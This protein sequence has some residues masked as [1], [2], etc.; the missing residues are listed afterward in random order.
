MNNQNENQNVVVETTVETETTNALPSGMLL[1]CGAKKKTRSEVANILPVNGALGARHNPI[2][3]IET[4][5][6]ITEYLIH[7]GLKIVDEGFGVTPDGNR[8]FGLMK[9]E[10]EYSEYAPTIGIARSYNQTL[11]A[12]LA[13][14][15]NI[16]VCDNLVFTGEIVIKTK[17]TTFIR[18]RMP[19]LIDG[20]VSRIPN[21]IE[22]QHLKFDSYKHTTLT[23]R[24]G[25]AAITELVRLGAVLPQQV[26]KVIREWDE[27]SHVEHAE[28]GMSVW[29]LNNA[30]TEAMKPTNNRDIVL[31]SMERTQI[32]TTF[33]DKVVTSLK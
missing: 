29:R 31:A 5:E 22:Q 28:D 2:P 7:Y 27:P 26:G 11:A 8:F 17:Q 3:Y 18:E 24:Q 14:G 21:M 32:L 20:A 30:V 25:D 16:F 15:A 4:I 23:A 6:Q 10:S 33:C 1:H 19:T 9:L 12:K 13:M